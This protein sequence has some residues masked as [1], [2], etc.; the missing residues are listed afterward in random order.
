MKQILLLM[1]MFVSVF[2]NAQTTIKMEKQLNG[3]YKVSCKVNGAPMKMLF[4]TGASSVSISRST[5]LYLLDNDLIGEDDYIGTAKT[6]IADGGI[7]DNMLIRLKDIEIGG[8]HLRNVEAMVTSSLTAPLL[9]GQSVISKL[10]KITLDGDILT[11]HSTNLQS[12][13]EE[14]RAELDSKLRKLRADR[15][16]AEADFRILE[17]VG[18]IEKQFELNELELFCKLMSEANH[19]KYDEAI[20]DAELW[21]DKYAIDSDNKDMKM[22][23]YF[24]SA[25]SNLLSDNGNKEL[26][27]Q[28]L[29]RCANYFTQDSTMHFYW[30]NL[31][32]MYYEF[33]KY[34]DIGY[35]EAIYAAK[36]S[37]NHFLK[38]SNTRLKD[39]NANRHPD[40]PLQVNFSFLP[41]IYIQHYKR[42]NDNQWTKNQVKMINLTSILAAKVGDQQAKEF[43]KQFDLDYKKP[44]TQKEL[45]FV[46][47]EDN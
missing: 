40:S 4:D 2:A 33:C 41:F 17:I 22:R 26:G 31:P 29:N 14:Q 12:L 7:V 42:Q 44:L 34:K 39:I 1:M 30:L 35:S 9:L 28:H 46:G 5:A 47:I 13:S 24:A 21:I 20:R 23:T 38:A 43:C 25:K 15:K 45:D 3:L 10:G 36:T 8:L 27:M 11:V 32:T 6:M 16:D 19:E 18:K 37:I